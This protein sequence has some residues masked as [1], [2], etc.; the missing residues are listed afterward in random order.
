MKALLI[1][2]IIEKNAYTEGGDNSIKKFAEGYNIYGS[3]KDLIIELEKLS[4]LDLI[5]LFEELVMKYAIQH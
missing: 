4:D 2:K 5:E 1:Q 3:E